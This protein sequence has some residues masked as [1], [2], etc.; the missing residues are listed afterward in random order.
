MLILFVASLPN[1]LQLP[2]LGQAKGKNRYSF[3][4]PMWLAGTKVLGSSFSALQ[5]YQHP[6][7]LG[8]LI[9]RVSNQAL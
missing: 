4:S 2:E 1:Y 9:S 8:V 6:A 7:G 3:R 5:V